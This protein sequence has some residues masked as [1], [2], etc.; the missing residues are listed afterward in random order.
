MQ[1]SLT[2][3]TPVHIGSDNV[4]AC[5]EA[6]SLIQR[7]T[8]NLE[9]L[10]RYDVAGVLRSNMSAQI[11]EQYMKRVNLGDIREHAAHDFIRAR[12]PL[13]QWSSAEVKAR[14]GRGQLNMWPMVRAGEKAYIPGS[15]IKGAIRTSI[16]QKLME[17]HPDLWASLGDGRIREMEKDVFQLSFGSKGG[18]GV[19]LMSLIGVGDSDLIQYRSTMVAMAEVR[20]PSGVSA[21]PELYEAI[22]PGVTCSFELRLEVERLR[23]IMAAKVLSASDM[24]MVMFFFGSK[25]DLDAKG[26]LEG[27]L[28]RRILDCGNFKAASI[29]SKDKELLQNA[30]FTLAPQRG[31][32]PRPQKSDALEVD[33]MIEKELERIGAEKKQQ[34]ILRLG[35][36]TGKLGVSLKSGASPEHYPMFSNGRERVDGPKTRK[37]QI[38]KGMVKGGF[39]WVRIGMPDVR[40]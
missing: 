38:E 12:L 19:D 3:L 4:E 30:R 33:G 2:T 18:P 17:E 35:R 8:D 24:E 28:F 5:T 10:C 21:I 31:N 32:G 9:L 36:G 11:L 25:G 15:S 1:L 34:A 26:D 6:N 20:Q 37:Y 16:L 29:R 14:L 40:V 39:G 22:A 27:M 7:T 13:D 23:K